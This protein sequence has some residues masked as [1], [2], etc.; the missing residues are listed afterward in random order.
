MTKLSSQTKNKY[1][2]KELMSRLKKINKKVNV[3]YTDF[4]KVINLKDSIYLNKHL[5]NVIK[6]PKQLKYEEFISIICRDFL[7]FFHR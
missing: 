6:K 7:K 1:S 5:L 3:D 4:V 2:P